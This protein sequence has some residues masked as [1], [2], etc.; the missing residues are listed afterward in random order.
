MIALK[1]IKNMSCSFTFITTSITNMKTFKGKSV[2]AIYVKK[3]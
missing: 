1:I 2:F 3:N